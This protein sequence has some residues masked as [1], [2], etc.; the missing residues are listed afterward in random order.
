VTAHV[1]SRVVVMLNVPEAPAAGADD[2]EVLGVT[3]HLTP[4]GA[5]TVIDDDPHAAAR[6]ASAQADN[7]TYRERFGTGAKLISS[8][9]RRRNSRRGPI[10]VGRSR[11]NLTAEAAV[12]AHQA[13]GS[14]R[15]RLPRLPWSSSVKHSP[16][17]LPRPLHE[18]HEIDRILD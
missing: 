7:A 14:R 11:C 10:R 8:I 6:H 5:S 13:R 1:Q 18:H 15:T 9:D 16:L 12:A 17:P 2:T 4:E 3:W